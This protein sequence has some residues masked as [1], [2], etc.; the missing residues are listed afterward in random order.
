MITNR[1]CALHS[2][3]KQLGLQIP[4]TNLD[5]SSVEMFRRDNLFNLIAKETNL[6]YS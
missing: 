6:Y 5:M 4:S 2:C 1:L 3:M